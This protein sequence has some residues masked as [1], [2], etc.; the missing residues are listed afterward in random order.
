MKIIS[1]EKLFFAATVSNILLFVGE[2]IAFVSAIKETGAFIFV[3]LCGIG[4]LLL[5]FSAFFALLSVYYNV[6]KGCGTNPYSH[7]LR[8]VATC[9]STVTL[10]V[11]LLLLLPHE[12]DPGSLLTSVS[13]WLFYIVCPLLSLLSFLFFEKEESRNLNYFYVPVGVALVFVYGVVMLALNFAEVYSGPY[14]FLRVNEQP[15][16]TVT[17]TLFGIA[18]GSAITSFLLCLGNKKIFFRGVIHG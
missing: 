10:V 7:T 1:E 6:R 17:L 18:L 12:K 4:N 16:R 3:R 15:T 14:Y 5:F 13:D 2:T 8:Y 11:F 9:V